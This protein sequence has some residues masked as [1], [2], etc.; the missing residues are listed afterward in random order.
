[1]SRTRSKALS[2]S[3]LVC[4]CFV[5]L[6]VSSCKRSSTDSNLANSVPVNNSA[7][8]VKTQ[9]TTLLEKGKELYKNDQDAD[10]AKVFE[11]ALA[12]DPDFAEAHYR[13]GLCYESMN[14]ADQAETEYKKAVES[15]KK[16]TSANPDD[17]EGHYQF[18][19]VYAALHQFSD[20]VREY[21]LAIKSKD[22]DADIYY[23]LGT[24]LM[25][26]AQYDEAVKAFSRSLE[27]DPENFRAEDALA[28]A[29]EGVQRIKAGRKHQ[30]DLLKKQKQDELKKAGEP[31]P[32]EAQST[33]G[34]N[35]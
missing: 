28:E 4:A 7:P 31:A 30:E 5:T 11:Q 6:F 8:S 35:F 16:Q 14:K 34:H 21:R 9:S 29:Q 2:S 10:A 18:G 15:Y 1:M 33:P 25:R 17:A 26:L 19:E 32:G 23:D 12:F 24:A 27:I 22:D 20:A 3:L 13:L